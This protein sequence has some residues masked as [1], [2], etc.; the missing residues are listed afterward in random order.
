MISLAW[1]KSVLPIDYKILTHIFK[2]LTGLGGVSVSSA[3][4]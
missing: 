2:Q 3:N 4:N 1:E